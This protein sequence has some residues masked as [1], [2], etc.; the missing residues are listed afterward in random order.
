MSRRCARMSPNTLPKDAD[1]L[2]A[3]AEAI[4]TVVAEKYPE[5]GGSENTEA[6]L[7]AS[8]AAATFA[9]SSYLAVLD[10][11]K[12]SPVANAFRIPARRASMRTEQQL[13]RRMTTVIASISMLHDPDDPSSVAEFVLSSQTPA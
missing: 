8:I 3:F 6:R 11:A 1:T 4:A 5:L 12:R 10:G 13:R 7:R 2:F 9:R